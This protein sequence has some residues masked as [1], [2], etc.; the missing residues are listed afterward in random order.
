MSEY[1]GEQDEGEKKRP[2]TVSQKTPRRE[3]REKSLEQIEEQ[4]EKAHTHAAAHESVSGARI[5]VLAFGAHVHPAK[6][7]GDQRAEHDASEEKSRKRKEKAQENRMDLG[8]KHRNLL[9]IRK[10]S[11]FFNK[12]DQKAVFKGNRLNCQKSDYGAW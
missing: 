7:A 4:A 2:P 12:K 9:F 6:P 8:G 5:A 10:Q 3:Y 1:G 11:S